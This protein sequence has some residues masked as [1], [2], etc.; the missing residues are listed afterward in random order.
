MKAMEKGAPVSLIFQSL[1]GSEAGN[2]EF[3]ISVD[4]LREA[5]EWCS[6]RYGKRPECDVF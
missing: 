4:I 3:G 6:N 5:R 1:A 2:R